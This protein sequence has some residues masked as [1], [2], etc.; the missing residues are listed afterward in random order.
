MASIDRILIIGTD[1]SGNG[2]VDISNLASYTVQYPKLWSTDSGRNMQGDM[3]ATLIG[4]FTKLVVEIL[5]KAFDADAISA[6]LD[7]V[8]GA[9][10]YV[11]Y[12]DIQTQSLRVEDFYFGDIETQLLNA[13]TNK[14]K[15]NQ[16]SIIA[17]KRR[18]L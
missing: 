2:G 14:V 11:K 7:V 4:I 15:V 1:S 5:D 13:P 17:N 6:I 18:S 12:Y 3:K 8:N 16:F 10:T 9:S